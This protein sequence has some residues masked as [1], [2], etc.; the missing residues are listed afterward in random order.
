MP[1]IITHAFTGYF[2]PKY[3]EKLFIVRKKLLICSLI[4]G[5][6]PDLDAITFKF[7]IPYASLFGHRGFSHSIFFAVIFSLLMFLIFFLFVIPANAGISS[8]E[9][10]VNSK[11]EIP[12]FAGMTKRYKMKK[13]ENILILSILFISVMSHSILDAMTNGGLGV[14]FFSPFIETRYFFPFRPIP[15]API[16]LVKFFSSWG[17]SV[18]FYEILIVWIPVILIYLIV[19]G[20]SSKNLKQNDDV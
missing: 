7:H 4:C 17:M 13:K 20:L 2:I 3:F 19:R 1:T 9:K 10:N 6:F 5:F 16:A 15:V 12:A 11:L 14:A 18:M 8:T